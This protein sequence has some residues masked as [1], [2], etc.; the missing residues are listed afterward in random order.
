[1]SLSHMK[2]WIWLKSAEILPDISEMS[3]IVGLGVEWHLYTDISESVSFIP[4]MS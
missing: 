4:E 3:K 1:M 2:Q